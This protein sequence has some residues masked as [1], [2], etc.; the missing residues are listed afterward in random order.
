M[1]A[2]RVDLPPEL[3]EYL[4]NVLTKYSRGQGFEGPEEGMIL[5]HTWDFLAKRATVV[6][7]EMPKATTAPQP[8]VPN[9]G[10]S[11]LQRGDV[12]AAIPPVQVPNPPADE[13]DL[14]D[15]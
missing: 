1:Q 13:D 2:I 3:H 4:L 8:R 12:E 7:L 10:V 5:F 11:T 14:G 6:E 15:R 9:D